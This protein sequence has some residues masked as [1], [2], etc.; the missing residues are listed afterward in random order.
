MRTAN[1][2]DANHVAIV[3]MFIDLGCSV[4][5]LSKVGSGV[6]DLLIGG[7]GSRGRFNV[8][9]EVKDGSKSPSKSRLRKNQEV[10]A[11]SWKGVTRVVRNVDDVINVYME[12]SSSFYR[13]E[14]PV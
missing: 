6:P 7:S 9:V 10:F 3:D 8:L 14:R 2:R 5:D 12:A 4:I 13:L 1:R 11:Q